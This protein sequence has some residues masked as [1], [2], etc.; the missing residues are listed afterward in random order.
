MEKS[1]NIAPSIELSSGV[2]HEKDHRKSHRLEVLRKHFDVEVSTNH[3]DLLLLACCLI[4]GFVDS[5]LYNG[6]LSIWP[7]H[8]RTKLTMNLAY[9]TFVSMQTGRLLLA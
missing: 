7:V 6:I 8:R 2:V 3:A 1:P 4:S 9:N 5:T